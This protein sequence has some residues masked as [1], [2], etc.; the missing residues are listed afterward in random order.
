MKCVNSGRKQSRRPEYGGSR[1]AGVVADFSDE[2]VSPTQIMVLPAV[3]LP[4]GYGDRGRLVLDDTCRSGTGTSGGGTCF[5][6]QSTAAQPAF[7][8]LFSDRA[9]GSESH[10]HRCAGTLNFAFNNWDLIPVRLAYAQGDI[11]R[12][13]SSPHAFGVGG[14]GTAWAGKSPN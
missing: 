3:P 4:G 14:D 11:G 1:C 12:A 13:P 7:L 9:S 8:L 6:P 5:L 2:Q 10:D